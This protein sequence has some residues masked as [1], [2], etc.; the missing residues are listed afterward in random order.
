VRLTWLRLE[1]A[2]PR[3]VVVCS[4]PAPLR[5]TRADGV[6]L[7]PWTLQQ[8]VRLHERAA[9]GARQLKGPSHA[10][11]LHRA[12]RRLLRRCVAWVNLGRTSPRA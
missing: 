9:V 6:T 8:A 1:H 12:V 7:D 3:R 10:R 5:L 2:A 11:S 4:A